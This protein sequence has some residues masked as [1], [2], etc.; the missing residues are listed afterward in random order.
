MTLLRAWWVAVSVIVGVLPVSAAMAD[1]PFGV[2][3]HI[4]TRYA[5]TG[6][7]SGPADLVAGLGGLWAREEFRF[8]VIEPSPGRWNWALADEMVAKL[9]GRGVRIL[10]LLVYSTGWATPGWSGSPS[11]I[12][13]QM[14]HLEAWRGFVRAVASRY[15]GRVSAWEIWNEENHDIFWRPRPDPIAYSRL[16]QAAYSEIKSVDPA[17]QVVIG[18]TSGVDVA[19][20]E[21]VASAGAWGNFDVLAVHPYVGKKSP[22]AGRLASSELAKARALVARLGHKPLW[23]TELGWTSSTGPWG[24]AS[25]DLQASYLVRGMVQGLSVGAERIFWYDL[26]NDGWDASNDE[27]NYGLVRR[28][29]RSLKPAYTAYRTLISVLGDATPQGQ[30]DLPTG[31]RTYLPFTEQPTAWHVW[32]DGAGGS[33]GLAGEPSHGGTGSLR[34][35]YGFWAPGKDYVDF[36]APVQIPGQPAKVGLWLWGD[37]SGHL[38]WVTFTDRSGERFMVSLGNV[39]GP[40]WH[41]RTA[42]L[43]DYFV[44]SGGNGDGRI[45]YPIT[46]Q[47]LMV[48]ND[49]DGK[50]GQGIL[51][52]DD[53]YFEEG[54]DVRVYRFSRGQEAVDVVWST[55]GWGSVSLPTQSP[56]AVVV[57]RDGR[58]AQVVA[59]GSQLR[60]DA[61][62]APRYVRH[63]PG[64]PQG[65]TGGTPSNPF[66][67]SMPMPGA[68]YFV[69]TGHNL[70]NGFRYYWE[71]NGGL[72]LFGFPISEEFSEDGLTV[73]YF[74]RARFEYHPEHK[75]TAFEVQ[76]TRLGALISQGRSFDPVPAFQ[77][78]ADR[79]YFPE[80]GH[81]LA[82]GFLS[83]WLSNG[84]LAAFGYPIS[85]EFTEVNPEDGKPY[86]V[87]YFERQRFEYHP[88]YAGTKYEV[89]LGLL[90]KQFARS[91]G[92]ME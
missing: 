62:T 42:K 36:S 30:L 37:N 67:R 87:Q 28:D 58:V 43:S 26:A 6:G 63:V 45:D 10:G 49:P 31:A 57:E 60:V 18:G 66:S 81:S 80:T 5:L 46:F 61:T 54:P 8:D 92:H 56:S 82:Y 70:A 44:S 27:H 78:T 41:L 15:R 39:E 50:T 17:A 91:R 14:P 64:T 59:Q 90:G 84:G 74:E 69:E 83:Y 86:T 21:A 53:L 76:L 68:R 4:A 72:E 33:A 7:L 40:G 85:E 47:S 75:G 65:Q 1:S 77:S 89:L 88:E 55:D 20:L 2:N 3:S 22:E 73:Q 34:L 29:W 35:E 11:A 48:D 24:V 51:Y 25:E 23:L 19:F 9:T 71:N 52:I 13:H 79:W 38:L 16:L 32:G 12:V